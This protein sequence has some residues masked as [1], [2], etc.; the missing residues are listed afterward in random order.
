VLKNITNRLGTYSCLKPFRDLLDSPH[1]IY[2]REDIFLLI[3]IYQGCGL[4]LV[5]LQ[6]VPDGV[7]LVIIPLIELSLT[8]IASTILT[9]RALS[10]G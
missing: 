2:G 1:S 4:S 5:D 3:K 9:G 7:F 8:G 10:T 6:T